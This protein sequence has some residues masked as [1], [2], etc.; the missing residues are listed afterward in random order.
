MVKNPIQ[1]D[2][3]K[4]Y[5]L[6]AAKEIIRGEGTRA[7]SVRTVAERAG[8]SYATLYNYY[9]D[10]RELIFYCISDFLVEL[11]EFISDAE[12]RAKKD[13][14]LFEVKTKA[15]ANYFVQY[16][17]TYAVIFTEQL[18]EIVHNEKITQEV[19]MLFEELF[20]WHYDELSKTKGTNRSEISDRHKYTLIGLLNFYLLRRT[21]KSYS[22]F[23]KKLELVTRY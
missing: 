9:K 6:S 4:S 20:G 18:T 7:L 17:G 21:P 22:E 12:G 8:Y 3:M 16:P 19:D 15:F 5:F 10:L 14:D 23:L 11:R 13:S 1:E 2:R